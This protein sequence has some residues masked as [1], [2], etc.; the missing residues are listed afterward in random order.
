MSG[1]TSHGPVA[2]LGLGARGG[3]TAAHLASHRETLW[4]RTSSVAEA[5]AERH[6]SRA[7][8]LADVA[9]A[10]V[11]VTCVSRTV[12]VVDLAR[13]LWAPV[14]RQVAEL[15]AVALRELGPDVGHTAALQLVERW[16]GT[17]IR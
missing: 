1:N 4:N 15:L 17:E 7:A 10:D 5:H 14:R 8:E 16:A 2:F 9:G 6:G 3:P 12:D 13:Q 11:L